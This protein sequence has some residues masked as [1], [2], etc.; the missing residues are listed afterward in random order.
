MR[1]RRRWLTASAAAGV[2]S[3]AP[4]TAFAWGT[5]GESNGQRAET[6]G[7]SSNDS[8]SSKV[9]FRGSVASSSGQGSGS[10]K[11]VGNWTP[12]ACW[13]EPRSAEEFSKYIEDMYE[14]TVNA[15]G[16]HSYAKTSAG[17]TREKYKDGKYK[18]YNLDQKN[19]GNWWVAVQDEDRWME[20]EAQ[21]CD[22]E[23][24]WAENGTA[25]PV[26]NAATPEVLAELAYNRIQLPTTKVTLAPADTTKVNLPTWAWLD[27]TR[28]DAVSVT[29]SLDAG[30]LNIEATTTATP[31]ALKLEPGTE[32]AETYPTSGECTISGDGS[33]GE[34]YAKGNA[35]QT[36]PC[37]LKYLRSSGDGTFDLQATITW[38]I[39]WTGTGG[40]GGD[41]P[42]GTFGTTQAITVQE[43]QSVN[44]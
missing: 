21:V 43:I 42:D 17:E 16:Q 8:I 13:Y 6:S 3:L 1:T 34:P 37:G 25:P 18:N 26:E 9:T 44:R 23:P 36:P 19:E 20:P 38:E 29:A 31:V 11:P 5:P 30:A 15:P 2:I 7:S 24:F 32:D 35:D 4:S 22:E 12:P 33:I 39:A 27:K 28:F 10:L 14:T 41:L 40:A